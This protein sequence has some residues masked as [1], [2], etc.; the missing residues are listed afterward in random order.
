MTG[1]FWQSGTAILVSASGGKGKSLDLSR[2][3]SAA[4][5]EQH[6]LRE[7]II[8]S[9]TVD[10]RP[11]GAA[12]RTSPET[13]ADSAAWPSVTGVTIPMLQ[14]EASGGSTPGGG[15]SDSSPQGPPGSAPSD[16]GLRDPH[17]KAGLGNSQADETARSFGLGAFSRQ[18][19]A[20]QPGLAQPPTPTP[21]LPPQRRSSSSAAAPEQQ[22]YPNTSS[23]SRVKAA[24]GVLSDAAPSTGPLPEGWPADGLSPKSQFCSTPP[25]KLRAPSGIWP[26]SSG[27]VARSLCRAGVATAPAGQ[28]AGLD[29]PL[30]PGGAQYASP[31]DSEVG[32]TPPLFGGA[33]ATAPTPPPLQQAAAAA[34]MAAA[35]AARLPSEMYQQA[36]MLATHQPRVERQWDMA[37]PASSSGIE[38]ESPERRHVANFPLRVEANAGSYSGAGA[39]TPLSRKAHRD[40]S[41]PA[42]SRGSTEA[43][44]GST[45]TLNAS[46]SAA[47]MLRRSHRTSSASAGGGP[48]GSSGPAPGRA[49]HTEKST[50]AMRRSKSVPAPAEK[51]RRDTKGRGSHAASSLPKATSAAAAG[52]GSVAAKV[53]KRSSAPRKLV[54][55]FSYAPDDPRHYHIESTEGRICPEFLPC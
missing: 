5:E 44:R 16:F 6:N 3:R 50:P 12:V 19:S 22:A 29:S 55:P 41:A 17:S 21:P 20:Q 13:S 48:P 1:S 7:R 9:N 23:P 10:S 15:G 52:A 49:G 51:A 45:V 11:L 28:S 26:M 34:G 33:A 36:V 31:D 14:R 18:G 25:L 35:A 24:A 42:Q 4:V 38:Q 2:P 27:D 46:D 47:V 37:L 40:G 39:E 32:A 8:S 43:H 30:L 54:L 53:R